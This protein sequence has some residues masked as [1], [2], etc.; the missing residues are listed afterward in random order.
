VDGAHA[1]APAELPVPSRPLVLVRGQR[2]QITVVNHLPQPTAIHWHGIELESLSDGVVG[3]GGHAASVTPSVEPGGSFVAEMTPPRAGTF[4][5]HTHFDD[6]IQLRGGLF[7][8]LIVL[9]P[10][11]TF[12][13][14]KDRVVVLSTALRAVDG[15]SLNGSP[16]P[17][18][19]EL[20]KGETYRFR[21]I[22][23]TGNDSRATFRLS[24]GETVANWR[25][26]AKD[27]AALPPALATRRPALQVVTV[28]E[29]RD[30][31]YTPDKPGVLTLAILDALGKESPT[32]LAVVVR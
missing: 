1:P 26:I 13:P 6:E 12:D 2:T 8:A 20:K 11:E 18:G 5:Y 16:T 17:A 31:E 3:W 25:A 22:N 4:I 14:E 32:K 23:I 21:L 19:M 27:G 30:F 10:G 15:P 28:G 7:G 29:T 9:E 24:A